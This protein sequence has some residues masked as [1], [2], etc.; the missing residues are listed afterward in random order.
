MGI[1]H[2]FT[3]A[4]EQSGDASIVSKN[5]WNADH[6]GSAEWD[7]IITKSS[8]QSVTN[9]VTMVDDTDLSWSVSSGET[10][11]FEMTILYEGTTACDYK[12][13]LAMS[14]GTMVGWLRYAGSDSTTNAIVASSGVRWLASTPPS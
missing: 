11:R 2:A 13:D 3:S 10:W 6:V 9:S 4:A 8:S 12:C 7:I 14:T 1:K 5:E